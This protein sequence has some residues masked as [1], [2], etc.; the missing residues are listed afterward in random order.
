MS[1]RQSV[2]HWKYFLFLL[3]ALL[4]LSGCGESEL[5]EQINTP[6]SPMPTAVAYLGDRNLDAAREI[7]EE[8]LV[9]NSENAEAHYHLGLILILSDQDAALSH[10]ERAEALDTGYTEPVSRLRTALRQ[11]RSIDDPVYRL[12]INGQAF[13]SI[14]AWVLAEIAFEEAV[15]LDS[16]YAEAWAY[17][18]ETRQH[19]GSEEAL[20]ALHTAHALKP[21]SFAANLFLSIYYRRIGQPLVA[22]EYI[23]T[24]IVSDPQNMNLQA[25]LAQ[26]L[27]EAG[28]VSK[29]FQ[30]L[31]DLAAESPDDVD[32]WLRLARL[33]I[34]NNLQV[35]ESG[36]PAARQVL[37]LA[38]DQSEA[39][40]LM[41]RGYLFLGDKVLAE[42]FLNQAIQMDDQL[43]EAPYFLG[44][45]YLNSGKGR[46]AKQHFLLAEKLALESHN[47]ILLEQIGTILKQ[48]YEE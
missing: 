40:L 14:E 24:A 41:G 36:L 33:S 32:S 28:G 7:W 6:V 2:I 9:A 31:E 18:G 29:G 5:P 1:A 19:T 38:P 37:L 34:D 30:I 48:Y 42:R 11:S 20:T 23:E 44:I 35:T 4:V 43:P 3:L 8:A 16:E 47:S 15:T 45:L 26:T 46:L 27:V 25:D 10:L 22:I 12:T 39:A 13:A 21:D 17:L